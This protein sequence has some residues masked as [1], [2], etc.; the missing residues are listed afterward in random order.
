MKEQNKYITIYSTP[1]R[2]LIS[3]LIPCQCNFV[4]GWFYP[5]LNN[6]MISDIVEFVN[7]RCEQDQMVVLCE[8]LMGIGFKYTTQIWYIVDKI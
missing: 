2:L 1:G 8:R 3:E 5:E 6:Q 4:Y 7:E